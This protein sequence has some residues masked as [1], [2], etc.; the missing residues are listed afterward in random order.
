MVIDHR[1]QQHCGSDPGGRDRHRPEAGAVKYV[2]EQHAEDREPP[3]PDDR[4]DEPQ[5][6]RQRDPT[7]QS[8]CQLPK[9]SVEI[10]PWLRVAKRA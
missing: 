8:A 3:D 6:D 4:C 2:G 1:A 7:P 10:H 9:S 5:Q